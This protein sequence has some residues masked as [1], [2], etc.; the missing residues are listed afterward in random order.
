MITAFLFAARCTK[1]ATSYDAALH[2]NNNGFFVGTRACFSALDA[3]RN[4]LLLS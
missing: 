3:K 2:R 1:A 4:Y